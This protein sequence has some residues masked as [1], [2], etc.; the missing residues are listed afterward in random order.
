MTVLITRPEPGATQ[1]ASRLRALGFDV[2]LE[3]LF[4]IVFETP[5]TRPIDDYAA[6]LFTSRNGVDGLSRL[7]APSTLSRL[8]A[9]AVGDRTAET[10]RQ[11]GFD[12]CHSASGTAHDLHDLIVSSIKDSE[13]PLLYAAGRD[14]TGDIEQRLK[15]S[16]LEVDLAEFYRTEPSPAL[17]PATITALTQGRI[18]SVLLYSRRTAEQ[19]FRLAEQA[20][21]YDGLGSVNFLC[22]SET[23][24]DYV[25]GKGHFSCRIAANPDETSLLSLLD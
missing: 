19:F 10:A 1:T 17:A 8:T 15:A 4:R 7:Y 13:K 22:L 9:F 21:I 3:P 6:V 23:I 5:T 20:D 24:C 11:A 16:G 25:K 12:T 18:D 14:R 2:M